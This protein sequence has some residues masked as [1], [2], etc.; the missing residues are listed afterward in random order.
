MKHAGIAMP[1][2][3]V[4]DYI[5]IL[6]PPLELSNK[7]SSIRD[8]FN[9][10]YKVPAT[11]GKPNLLLCTFTQ[12]AMMEE[13]IVNNLHRI[14][15]GYPPFKVEIKDF[16]SFP[17]HTVYVNV[18]SKVPIQALV[19][20]IRSE[21]QALMKFNDEHKPYFA[22]EP[23]FT[24]GRKLKPWQYEKAW[25]EYSNLHFTGRFIAGEML[26]LKREHGGDKTWQI[27]KHFKFENLPIE[28]KQAELFQ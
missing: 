4:N 11:P 20:K 10:K 26:L 2:Y 22:S 14:A 16:G 3:R 13:R 8:D 25:I 23:H 24:L 28:T 17:T 7:L 6:N 18:N 1:G 5:L 27:V 21:T 9:K 12:Y 15:M 19:R